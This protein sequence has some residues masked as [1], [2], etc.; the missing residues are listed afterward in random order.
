MIYKEKSK[1][2]PVPKVEQEAGISFRGVWK[3]INSPVLKSSA[4]DLSYLLVHNKL[5]V[6]ERLFRVGL[7]N[8][9]YCDSCLGLQ[10]HDAEHFFCQ[11][12]KVVACWSLVRPKITDMIGADVPDSRLIGYLF[13][14]C[15]REKEVV[16][17]LGNYFEFVWSKIYTKN[18]EGL[19]WEE[20]YGFLKFKYRADQLG[21]RYR[22]NHIPGLD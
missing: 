4:Q 11:C 2:F 10:I 16:W 7:R 15:E 18:E 12:V 22:L 13:P 3:L 6:V 14:K 8:D 1:S 19:Q 5:P 9:P 17:L 20:L 21:A